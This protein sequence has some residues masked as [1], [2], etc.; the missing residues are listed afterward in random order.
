MRISDWS[1]DVCSSDLAGAR[2]GCAR[3]FLPLH[4]PAYRRLIGWCN[5]TVRIAGPSLFLFVRG[6]VVRT[7]GPLAGPVARP[8]R[9]RCH[10]PPARG[11]AVLVAGDSLRDGV[12]FGAVS[13]G[14]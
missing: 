4:R 13:A 6:K 9:W 5:G 11:F 7:Q 3:A 10:R 14:D 2:E 1:S 12:I 8:M